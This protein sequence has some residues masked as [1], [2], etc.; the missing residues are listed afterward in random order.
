LPLNERAPVRAAG[1]EWAVS[2]GCGDAD[3]LPLGEGIPVGPGEVTGVLGE[4]ASEL[5]TSASLS[6]LPPGPNVP[7]PIIPSALVAPKTA[8]TSAAA[9][10]TVTRATRLFMPL[11]CLAG[12]TAALMNS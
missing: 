11:L 2:E 3:G 7:P 5:R 12:G 10:T 6:G 1:A 9:K 4:A 8:A